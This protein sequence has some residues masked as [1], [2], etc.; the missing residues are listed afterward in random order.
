MKKYISNI[1]F[2]VLLLGSFLVSAQDTLS[3]IN[4][5]DMFSLSGSVD[6]YYK[7]DLAGSAARSGNISGGENLTFFAPDHNSFS[8]GMANIIA[9]KAF[10][11]SSVVA[12]F[13]FGPRG[14]HSSILTQDENDGSFHIQ[15]LYIKHQISDRFSVTAGFMGTF[16]GY[17]VISPSSNFNYSTSY[18]FS[19][20]PFQNAGVRFDFQLSDKIGLMAGIFN[21]WNSYSD[22]TGSK[23]FGL[24]LAYHPSEGKDIFLNMITGKNSG[25]ELDVTATFNISE[26][27]FLGLNAATYYSSDS[28]LF[29]SESDGFSGVAIYPQFAISSNVVLGWRSEIFSERQPH[30]IFSGEFSGN[31]SVFSNT[32]SANIAVGKITIIPEFRIDRGNQEIFIDSGSLPTDHASQVLLALVYNL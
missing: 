31:A 5:K 24:Q 13:S 22:L 23:D 1:T 7:Y 9:E 11:K 4:K 12:D 20:G 25:T 19:W 27:L 15:N 6:I 26:R 32:L 29:E 2:T 18:L 3:T 14:A 8:I 21:D 28:D 30:N 16:L 10:G 17:E